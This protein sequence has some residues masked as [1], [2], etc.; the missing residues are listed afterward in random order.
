MKKEKR[1]EKNEEF[2][3]SQIGAMD[4][5]L[6][7]N[8]N[9][10][11]KSSIKDFVDEEFENENVQREDNMSIE[12]ESLVDH[13]QENLENE[14]N[15]NEQHENI[16]TKCEPLHLD[17]SYPGNWKT[18]DQNLIDLLVKRGS[19]RK[20]VITFPKDSENRHFSYAYYIRHLAN[21]EKSDR[22][23]LIYSILL[24]KV[25][26]FYCKLFKQEGNNIQLANEG[27][28]D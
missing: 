8:I 28:N 22:K 23:W 9:N 15:R 26:C 1:K 25:F 6:G 19:S 21:G 2:I 20:N 4:K 11:K 27:I 16:N 18:L 5:F 10:N 7:S 24:D 12:N 14:E 17:I 13:E 3:Q